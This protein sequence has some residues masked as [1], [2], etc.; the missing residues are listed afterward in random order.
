MTMTV[1]H[2]FNG[3]IIASILLGLCGIICKTIVVY[4]RA[5]FDREREREEAKLLR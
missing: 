2:V 4:Q 3:L 1:L 5:E